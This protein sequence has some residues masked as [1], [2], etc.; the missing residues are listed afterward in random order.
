MSDRGG[1]DW[2]KLFRELSTKEPYWPPQVISGTP[3]PQLWAVLMEHATPI[4]D[5]EQPQ[6]ALELEDWVQQWRAEH[7]LPP[8]TFV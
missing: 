8:V 6:N 5:P 3:V 7:G 1:P 2:L 4:G